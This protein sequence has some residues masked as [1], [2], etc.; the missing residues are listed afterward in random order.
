MAGRP[1]GGRMTTPP[2]MLDGHT[3]AGGAFRAHFGA[4]PHLM[5]RAPG[6]VNLL[7]E[8]AG[9]PDGVRLYLAVEQSLWLALRPRADGRVILHDADRAE[10]LEFE[11]GAPERSAPS[12]RELVK[13]VAAT[14]HGAGWPLSGWEGCLAS[15]IPD[16]ADFAAPAA[17]ALAV[18]RAFSERTRRPWD[19]WEAARLGQQARLGWGGGE[20]SLYDGW[21]VALAEERRA[22][23]VDP[24]ARQAKAIPLPSYFAWILL[25]NGRPAVD[26][27]AVGNG[28]ESRGRSAAKR[29][30]ALALRDLSL[31]QF[32]LQA[33]RLDEDA[34]RCARH[35][36]TENERVERAVA[37]MEKGDGEGLGILMSMSHASLRDDFGAGETE[38]DSL[39]QVARS[40]PGCVGAR[41]C[42][43]LVLALVAHWSLPSFLNQ[44]G[45]AIQARTGLQPRI[46][47]T[48]ATSGVA[49]G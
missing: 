16:Q 35:I 18:A 7:G 39:A 15:D 45:P 34:R 36:M 28:R 6:R 33:S 47:A 49:L 11:A 24:R 40:L 12:W 20:F 26:P 17:L 14:L 44:I 1:G 29:M 41:A 48:H 25:V 19:G 42:A 22:L 37:A 32:T 10:A 9:E 27:S 21:A 2:L 30:G 3:R 4:S 43:G 38:L 13:G 31:T 23:W 46:M 5:I 8:P